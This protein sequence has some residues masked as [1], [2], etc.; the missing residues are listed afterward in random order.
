MSKRAQKC[1]KQRNIDLPVPLGRWQRRCC[2]APGRCPQCPALF[3]RPLCNKFWQ[4]EVRIPDPDT[5]GNPPVALLH[6]ISYSI[7]KRTYSC[8]N[9]NFFIYFPVAPWSSSLYFWSV[10][11]LCIPLLNYVLKTINWVN[12]YHVLFWDNLLLY[13]DSFYFISNNP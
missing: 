3:L 8:R 4:E 12:Q 2:R 13:I 11:K 7:L 1:W 6:N 9:S 10:G 5:L